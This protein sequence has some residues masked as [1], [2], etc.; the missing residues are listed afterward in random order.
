MRP[1]ASVTLQKHDLAECDLKDVTF[2]MWD[3]Q[4]ATSQAQP[5]RCPEVPEIQRKSYLPLLGG[6]W[7]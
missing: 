3:V 6:Q 2:W 5:S 4:D 7:L 1:A